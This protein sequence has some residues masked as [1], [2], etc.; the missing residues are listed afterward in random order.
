MKRIW[1]LGGLTL[2]VACTLLN[3]L[4]ELSNGPLVQAD[5][6]TADAPTMAETG[7]VDSGP[8]P[9]AAPKSKYFA[10]VMEDKPVGYWRLG[11]K[12]GTIAKDQVGIHDG[13]YTGGVTL[14]LT[15][16]DVSDGDT[17]VSFDGKSGRVIIADAFGF[18]N[19]ASF[20]V[21]SWV[22]IPTPDSVPHYIVSKLATD[23]GAG[24]FVAEN[25]EYEGLGFEV[26]N[27]GLWS[28]WTMPIVATTWIHHVGTFTAS[29]LCVYIN[30]VQ[31]HCFAPAYG[32]AENSS[33][34]TI[35]ATGDGFGYFNGA[36]DEVAIYDHVLPPERVQAHYDAR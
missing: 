29:N 12:G 33:A 28:T 14:G 15:R 5:A 22:Y 13:T 9:D 24:W 19:N 2:T 31:K 27:N 30:G 34:L 18:A 26:I 21:E 25:R 1:L 23:A 6:H 10:A 20:S 8:E 17:A 16:P 36:I 4:D 35:G 11:E 32:P 7:P 3:P